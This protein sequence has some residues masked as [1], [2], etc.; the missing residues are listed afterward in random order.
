MGTGDHADVMFTTVITFNRIHFST[1]SKA[2][3]MLNLPLEKRCRF[4]IETHVRWI[5]FS[6]GGRNNV[7]GCVRGIVR[8]FW[9]VRNLEGL[10]S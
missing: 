10:R 4:W 9:Y 5:R 2:L 8:T 6:D 7:L 1:F 3:L